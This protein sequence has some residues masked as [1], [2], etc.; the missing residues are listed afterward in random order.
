MKKHT[1]KT[2][3]T[4]IATKI[5]EEIAWY[6]SKRVLAAINEGRTYDEVLAIVKEEAR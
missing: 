1:I 4:A 2:T 6:T 3:L 5:R